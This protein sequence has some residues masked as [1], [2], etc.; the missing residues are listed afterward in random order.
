MLTDVSVVI[1]N[2]NRREWGFNLNE[3]NDILD[4]FLVHSPAFSLG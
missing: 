3:F 1:W 4:G 2:W